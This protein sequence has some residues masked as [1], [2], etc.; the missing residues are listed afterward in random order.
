[1]VLLNAFYRIGLSITV[2]KIFKKPK[3]QE[4]LNALLIKT[5]FNILHLVHKYSGIIYIAYITQHDKRH[6]FIQL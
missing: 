6:I 4:L 1:M 3:R 5:V 2:F